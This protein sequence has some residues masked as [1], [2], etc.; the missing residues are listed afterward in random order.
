MSKERFPNILNKEL[1]DTVH[2]TQGGP[3]WTIVRKQLNRRYGCKEWYFA[4][5]LKR[6][7]GEKT[8]R[9]QANRYLE[10]RPMIAQ[11][12]GVNQGRMA[13]RADFGI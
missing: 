8:E 2:D 10:T 3:D 4:Y 5:Y 9:T 13:T 12:I 7:V 6:K 1:D 11:D